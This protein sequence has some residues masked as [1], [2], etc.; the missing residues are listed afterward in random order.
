M[1]K[2]F[3]EKKGISADQF[4]ELEET[5]Q[6][7]LQNE[8]LGTIESELS[9]KASESDVKAIKEDLKDYVSKSDFA[10][11]DKD[12]EEL[13][14]KVE[15]NQPKSTDKVLATIKVNKAIKKD[16]KTQQDFEFNSVIKADV[17]HNLFVID[18][19]TFDEDEANMDSAMLTIT[20][21]AP[22]FSGRQPS[23]QVFFNTIAGLAEPILEGQSLQ[24]A[25]VHAESGTIAVTGEAQEKPVIAE[26]VKIQ[27]EEALKV[28]AIWY[29]TK[30]FINRV[31]VFGSPFRNNFRL[32]FV[33][34]LANL[35]LTK[36][37]AVA[38]SWTLPTGFDLVITPN[39]Y[40]A[41]SAIATFIEANKYMPTH[42]VINVV[43]VANMFTAKGLDG[44]YALTNGGSVQVINGGTTL[45]VN[46]SAIEMIKVDSSI[47]AQGTVTMFD[48]NKLRFGLSPS[49]D[50]DTNPY[51][52]W[53]QNIIGFKLEGAYAVLLP[54][55]HPNAVVS[56]T[57][58]EVIE[59]ITL[60]E[61]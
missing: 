42:V 19:G 1:F 12:I 31:G 16:G 22:R 34:K 50:F 26:K 28:P 47:Q 33:D 58:A 4:K 60:I 45:L 8:Y 11:L 46:G 10:K 13:A 53:T 41:L 15:R 17:L 21:G 56:T 25:I 43:D 52:Y 35:I 9:K 7:E 61:S 37:N 2:K 27:K 6:A 30:E 38:A 39:N 36:V 18:G 44:H 48:V 57:F 5:K 49:V 59:D 29:E 3:L 54:E 14:L 32:K 23:S 20:G 40:D 55:N 51:E 24:E